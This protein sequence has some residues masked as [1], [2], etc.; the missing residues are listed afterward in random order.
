MEFLKLWRYVSL[1]GAHQ[2]RGLNIGEGSEVDAI[3][4]WDSGAEG[5]RG[6]DRN[7]KAELAV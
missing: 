5:N 1:S 3:G 6:G 4:R 7:P 2:H